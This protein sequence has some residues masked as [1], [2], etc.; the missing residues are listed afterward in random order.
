MSF[1]CVSCV[2]CVVLLVELSGAMYW[3][4]MLILSL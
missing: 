4:A 3:L 2:S 1:M